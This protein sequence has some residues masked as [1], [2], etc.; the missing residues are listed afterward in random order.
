MSFP[1][2][3]AN[4]E[5]TIVNGISYIYNTTKNSWT[6]VPSTIIQTVYNQANTAASDAAGASLYANGAFA[7]ANNSI[8]ADTGGTS[9]G[10]VAI[11]VTD[12]TN[13]ALR[14]TQ[15]G[16]GNAFVVE[17]SASPDATPF[18]IDA[19]GQVITGYTTV[20]P[21]VNYA[22][23]AITPNMELHGG[24][25]APGSIGAYVWNVTGSNAP[26]LILN[27]SASGT[28][29]TR[30]V[31]ASGNALG[32][33]SFNGDDGTS[34]V[35]GA[36]ITA[37]VDGIPS[38]GSMPGR[39][40]FSTTAN[41]SSSTTERM[42]IDSAG[43]VGVGVTPAIN[44]T[45]RVSKAVTGGTTAGNF[46]ASGVTQSDVTS[47]NY[48]FLS[49]SGTA[50]T[51]FTLASQF[52][53][54]AIQG[55]FG[56]GSTVTNQYGFAADNG[57]I[58]ATNNFGF[59]S[60]LTANTGRY[61]FYA[62]GDADNY[63]AGQM[64]IGGLPSGTSRLQVSGNTSITGNLV[65][66]GTGNGI[67]FAD[68]TKMTTAAS[69]GGGGAVLTFASTP[70]A[71]GNNSGDIWVDSGDGTSYTYYNDGDSSQWVDSSVPG[72]G[73]ATSISGGS[74]G[75]ILYQSATSNTA[76]AA[77]GSAG[78]ILT[79]NGSAS[80]SW[81]AQTSLSIATTQLTGNITGTQINTT[82]NVQIGA[83]GVGTPSGNTGE[84]RATN[85][86]TAYY[87]DKRLKTN[88]RLI[89]NPI[90]KIKKISGVYYTM[91]D[92]AKE[93]GYTDTSR[94]VGVIAQE[95]EAVLPEVVTLAPI[96]T[97]VDEN[98]N[99]VS[100]SGHNYK[101]VYYEKIIP[102]LIESIKEQQ[103]DIEYLKGIIN[104]N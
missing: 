52:H 64:G 50:A 46:Y 5:T 56:A 20:V 33:V 3:P 66:S 95:L 37:L 58:G 12:N 85:N 80:P 49:Q 7:R 101:T 8:R 18:V 96:D 93:L 75:A 69:G 104:G 53:F 26:N 28:T 36:S 35:V 77:V 82:A 13:A 60:G 14:I 57:L 17:D 32:A 39:L 16:A 98:G 54:R 42:R 9:L 41:G 30:G 48:G 1:S 25:M 97:M 86:I 92:V 73:L 99:L 19:I 100:K 65:L 81:I 15:N 38:T 2:T 72:Y 88:I 45:F 102:L 62:A 68:G 34:F 89:D 90:E 78:Q 84:I 70:P 11:S 4:N 103:K 61:N 24:S 21:T 22:G 10:N 44:Y 29:G 74:A 27:K 76:F 47:A 67:V 23:N 91:N 51:A 71:S 59:H 79:V 63:F 6:R 55:T 83:L 31:V 87:S 94:Q 40:I 43:N